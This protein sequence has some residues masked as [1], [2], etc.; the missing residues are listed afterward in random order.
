MLAGIFFGS[1]FAIG[2]V[3]PANEQNSNI[4]VAVTLGLCVLYFP[5]TEGLWGRTLGKLFAGTMV[6]DKAGR[7]PGLGRA[8]VRTL[9]RLI[10][11]NPVLLGGVPAGICVLATKRKQRIGDLVA[12]TYVLSADTLRQMSDVDA[13]LAAMR[14]GRAT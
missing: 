1:A 12:G 14:G 7:V 6:V 10:E 5:L 13:T 4:A 2:A 8:L 11:V 3:V 9:F